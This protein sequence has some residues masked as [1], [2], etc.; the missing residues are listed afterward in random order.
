MSLLFSPIKLN[1][2]TLKNRIL[3]SP[4]CQYSAEDGFANDWHLVH[5]GGRAVGGAALI[6]SEAT[7]VSPEGRISPQ[8]LGIWKDEHIDKLRQIT[9]FIHQQ[10]A[11]AGI[12]LAHAGR[13]AST[14]PPW[15][16]NK[17]VSAEHG[18][19]HPVAPSAV[20]FHHSEIAPL[21]LDRSGIENVITDFKN[22]AK[23]AV[24]AGFDVIEIHAAHGYLL[25]Q[26]LS[27]LS[28]RREDEYGGSFENRI[29]LLLD[30]VA[31]IRKTIPEDMPLLVRISATDYADGGWDVEQSV[32]LSA[33][34]K[35]RGVDMMD[36]SSGA[37]IP[38]VKIPVGPGYQVDFAA[39]IKQETSIITG[40][41]GLITT[42]EQAEEILAE[43]KAD[44]I[45]MA[46]ELLRNSYFPLDASMQLDGDAEYPLQYERAKPKR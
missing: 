10:N 17:Q 20:P 27:P 32:Q 23:R 29:R 7:A 24:A 6:I 22:A 42:A 26:F 1:G 5:L 15:A 35:E 33:I 38:G 44:V 18:G 46:R 37:L 31:V 36:V 13:K 8:D 40:A 14:E 4:M 34:L 25:H 43:N 16:G 12:Q 11:Y 28:N 19:W 41:V 45:L 39:Q 3:V 21:G 2:I 30:I 9:D